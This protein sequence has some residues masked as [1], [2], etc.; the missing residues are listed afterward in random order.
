MP[1]G[2]ILRCQSH[3]ILIWALFIKDPEPIIGVVLT[4]Y[5]FFL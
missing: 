2:L 5:R 1:K 4:N 3:M